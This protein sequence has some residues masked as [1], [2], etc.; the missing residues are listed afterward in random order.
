LEQLLIPH[1]Q[2]GKKPPSTKSV[3]DIVSAVLLAAAFAVIQTLI[4]G[5]RLLFSFPAYALL[6]VM[7]LVTLFSLRR[8][9]AEP[10]ELCL[11]GAVVFFGYILT[12]ALFSPAEYLARADVYSVFAG[13]LVYLFV[14]CV[15]TGAKQRIY[16]LLFLLAVALVHVLIGIV[17]FRNDDNFMPIS[18]LH[19][20]DYGRRASGFYIC[21]N[22]LAGLLEVLGIFGLS[23][24]C[25]SRYRL[26]VKLAVGYVTAV[27]YL[28]LILTGSRGGYLSTVTSLIVFSMISLW[29]S[30]RSGTAS[31]WRIGVFGGVGAVILAIVVAFFVTKNAFLSARAHNIFETNNMRLGLWHAALEQWKL[32][33]IVGTGSGTYLYYGRQ[34]RAEN[35]QWDPVRAHNDYLDLLAEYGCVGAAAFLI[36]F[37][38]HLRA[39]WKNLVRSGSKNIASST[40]LLSNRLALQIGAIGAVSAYVIHSI[41]D[42]NLHIPANIVLLAFVFGILANPGNERHDGVA[43][44]GWSIVFWRL[45]PAAIGVILLIQCIRLLPGEYFAERARVALRREH[46]G[47]TIH[48]AEHGLA[49]EGNNP[50]LY[51]YLGR[52]Q[53]MRGDARKKPDESAWFY[54]RALEAFR[55]GRRLAP[56]DE[57]FALQ[58]AYTY[59]KLGRFKEAEWMYYEALRLDPKSQWAK[60]FYQQH[61]ELW[62]GMG[63]ASS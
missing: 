17:Q 43:S 16:F 53:L 32:A 39:A 36:F 4:G 9:R 21:P 47:T 40:R 54:R 38:L 24:A 10:N 42:F 11:L 12:R 19:R 15:F 50:N 35:M 18:W 48:F 13:L 62:R 45:V 1:R 29:L 44:P 58:L 41:F 27:C 31:F 51:D 46:A 3:V 33:P 14:A 63:R 59:D 28:G 26:S 22:H 30:R 7:A 25:W 56:L 2:V 52:A 5:T 37:I 55:E 61:L 34:F 57:D 6:A 23:I 20:F 60:Y 8:H 49:S